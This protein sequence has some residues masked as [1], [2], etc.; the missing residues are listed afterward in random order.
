[1]A[2]DSEIEWFR[3]A[4]VR[5]ASGIGAATLVGWRASELERLRVNIQEPHS[6]WGIAIGLA[7]EHG[8]KS[9]LGLD[10]SCCCQ[11]SA[12]CGEAQIDGLVFS[13]RE[14]CRW[15]T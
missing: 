1:M 13:R 9:I 11:W 5:G 12:W 3:R 8:I 2:Y 15:H 10:S 4:P 14:Q 6:T 7:R